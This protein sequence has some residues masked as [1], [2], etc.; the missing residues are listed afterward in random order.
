MKHAPLLENIAK[1]LIAAL[2]FIGVGMALGPLVL[3]A[4]SVFWSRE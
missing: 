4:A 3:L 1:A 2:V